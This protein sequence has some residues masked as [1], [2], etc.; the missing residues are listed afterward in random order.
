MAA[1]SV[2]VEGVK[3]Q[4]RLTQDDLAK[5]FGRYGQL[6]SVEVHEDGSCA[7]VWFE[8][9]DDADNSI[10]ELHG[11]QLQGGDEGSLVVTW[12]TQ[13]LS[14]ICPPRNVEQ[15]E[16]TAAG[17]PNNVHP[18]GGNNKMNKQHGGNQMNSQM[19]M[20]SQQQQYNN[21]GGANFMGNMRGGSMG[22]N[23]GSPQEL[24]QGGN[25]NN[26][27]NNRK[28]TCRIDI[29]LQNEE[30]FCVAKKLIGIKGANMKL[31][32]QETGAKLRLRGKDSGYLEGSNNEESQEPLHLCVSCTDYQGYQVAKKMA[33]DV[34]QST[35]QE[36]KTFRVSA[37]LECPKLHVKVTEHPVIVSH[38]KT[39]GN[40][41][42]SRASSARGNSK[43][44]RGS[45]GEQNLGNGGNM[46]GGNGAAQQQS[47]GS[48]GAQ[49]QQQQ[50]GVTSCAT[51]GNNNMGSS[52]SQMNNQDGISTG[53]QG[54]VEGQ[55]GGRVP[56]PW[57]I[58]RL[59]EKRNE[60]RRVGNY[61]EADRIR[62][63]LHERGVALMDEPGGR[64]RGNDVTTWRYFGPNAPAGHQGGTHHSNH[65]AT[66]GV[67]KGGGK[68]AQASR[69]GAPQA[70]GAGGPQGDYNQGYGWRNKPAYP[71]NYY[72]NPEAYPPRG[73][74]GFAS[75][76]FGA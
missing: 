64:G 18:A 9:R 30:N 51:G 12:A 20:N 31:I 14:N 71:G 29:G 43:Q 21:N 73:K 8:K 68:G 41:E 5:V 52:T 26:Q 6:N 65:G 70:Y 25:N 24:R 35:L 46:N 53:A 45:P 38:R 10:R 13:D 40:G 37:G 67:Q 76:R 56:K 61:E 17:K 15:S 62:Q 33:M 75:N 32:V 47:G 57:E 44:N 11:K 60:S 48:R 7:R 50:Q 28:Y 22:N 16:Q 34:I 69:G 66:S 59:V 74:Y 23:N 19:N 49:Q 36:Y 2:S 63:T 55:S 3:F 27:R 42:P 1:I 39:E 54:G 72:E 4:Y 58:E